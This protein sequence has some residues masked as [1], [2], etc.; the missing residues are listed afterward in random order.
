MPRVDVGR[1]Y[2]NQ[3]ARIHIA[4]SCGPE[5]YIRFSSLWVCAPNQ[6]R[7][8]WDKVQALEERQRRTI[9]PVEVLV[10]RLRMTLEHDRRAELH[11]IARPS[12]V[13]GTEDDATVPAYFARDL[14]AAIRGSEL[15]LM[16]EGGHYCY[17]RHPD[18]YNRVLGE[19]LE[20]RGAG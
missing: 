16:R 6:F 20:R 3:T 2:L 15:Y 14:H 11:R 18:E 1:L 8:D 4:E 5:E 9:G 12:L 13:I 10:A 19:F 7:Y 17:R